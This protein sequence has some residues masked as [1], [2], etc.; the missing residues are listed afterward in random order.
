MNNVITMNPPQPQHASNMGFEERQELLKNLSEA[1]GLRLPSTILPPGTALLPVGE[2][3][4]RRMQK[5]IQAL[6]KLPVAL[7]GLKYRIQQMERPEDFKDVPVTAITMRPDTGGLYRSDRK[8]DNALGYTD[9]AFGHLAAILKPDDL[10]RNGFAENLL[11]YPPHLRAVNFAHWRDRAMLGEDGATTLRTVIEPL[12]QRRVI[13]AFTSSK[14]SL[15]AGDDLAVVEAMAPGGNVLGILD[16]AHARIT[17]EWDKTTFELMWPTLAHEVKVGD[18]CKVFVR[19]RN[20]ETKAGALRVE[21]GVLRVR[22]YNFTT[23]E[24]VD[25]DAKDISLRHLGDLRRKVARCFKDALDRVEPL[26]HAF[27]DAYRQPLPSTRGEAMEKVRRRFKLREVDVE[28]AIRV[29]DA[30]DNV[31]GGDTLAGLANALTARARELPD[32][33]ATD[34]ERAAGQLLAMGVKVLR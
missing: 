13:R 24:S 16:N 9:S 33:T 19:V 8:A 4:K 32:S 17:R 11:A 10:V 21:A 18:I 1:A 27:G 14:H 25:L 30:P 28:E 7:A 34:L 29:W 23:A 5:E 22:C 12:S 2:E 3:N 6:P 26:V 15:A 31:G 20:S